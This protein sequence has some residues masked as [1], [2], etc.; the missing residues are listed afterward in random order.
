[1]VLTQCNY[2]PNISA[3][4]SR[5][6]APKN[7]PASALSNCQ[8]ANTSEKPIISIQPEHMRAAAADDTSLLEKITALTSLNPQKDE[9]TLLENTTLSLMV[10]HD[11]Q[12]KLSK[13]KP[14]VVLVVNTMINGEKFSTPLTIERR[15]NEIDSL[16]VFNP[17]KTFHKLSSR[18]VYNTV[19][20]ERSDLLSKAQQE[21]KSKEK[22]SSNIH[23]KNYELDLTQKE[24]YK[25]LFAIKQLN[26][27]RETSLNKHSIN[28][29]T[30]EKI[31]TTTEETY[32][33]TL[34]NIFNN[35]N[36]LLNNIVREARKKNKKEYS[37]CL[38]EEE[39]K[40]VRNIRDNPE[41]YGE[42]SALFK[43]L[44]TNLIDPAK[45]EALETAWKTAWKVDD[46]KTVQKQKPTQTRE[47][48]TSYNVNDFYQPTIIVPIPNRSDTKPNQSDVISNYLT[49]NQKK[50]TD[51]TRDIFK[52]IKMEDGHTPS[53]HTLNEARI[54]MTNSIEKTRIK[55]TAAYKKHNDVITKRNKAEQ[56]KT[57]K[58]LIISCLL[59]MVVLLPVAALPLLA[60]LA[61]GAVATTAVLASIALFSQLGGWGF[62]KSVL[63]PF[64]FTKLK[65]SLEHKPAKGLL[66][67]DEMKEFFLTAKNQVDTFFHHKKEAAKI[68]KDR[69]TNEVKSGKNESLN[70]LI[71]QKLHD[72]YADTLKFPTDE[73]LKLWIQEELTQIIEERKD[74]IKKD[75]AHLKA[76][77]PFRHFYSNANG[78]NSEE[79]ALYFEKQLWSQY[80]ITH[81]IGDPDYKLSFTQNILNTFRSDTNP[82]K[83]KKSSQLSP[84]IIE[85]LHELKVIPSTDGPKKMPPKSISTQQTIELRQWA[86]A[87][88]NSINQNFSIYK[89][90]DKL[91]NETKIQQINSNEKEEILSFS[92]EKFVAI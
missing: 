19:W 8:P 7:G 52:G 86:N 90:L 36:T 40:I 9:K 75:M 73:E 54:S 85:R 59:I 45:K 15:R 41:N 77:T 49:T 64:F 50:I 51:I 44:L 53:T 62:R 57:T 80:I 84:V 35:K 12:S 32:F 56:D 20:V 88:Y 67:P 1:M 42:S 92:Q 5:K 13:K 16:S 34:S 58:K 18:A 47:I 87:F 71:R 30:R 91:M 78:E 60:S 79:N 37:G 22:A 61:L 21:W 27:T 11:S 72:Y 31:K 68:E 43:H 69:F 25:L 23:V 6:C 46:E 39:K 66:T 2:G 28:S 38:E 83:L 76:M 70:L 24:I 4:D 55:M 89:G 10:Y 74:L 65:N 17:I 26:K 3:P 81:H 48:A 14:K 63:E 82:K 29:T 33:S